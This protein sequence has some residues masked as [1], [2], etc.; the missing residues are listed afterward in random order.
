M[1][2]SI[3]KGRSARI[4]ITPRRDTS[5]AITA[6]TNRGT[7]TFKRVNTIVQPAEIP[8]SVYTHIPIHVHKTL[9]FR[10]CINSLR[11]YDYVSLTC[12]RVV[13]KADY[14]RWITRISDIRYYMSF[15]YTK[16]PRDRSSYYR[17]Y[18]RVVR[19]RRGF[20]VLTLVSK[21]SLKLATFSLGE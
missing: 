7:Y 5:Q 13:A 2:S 15:I 20:F 16:F 3:Y 6:P 11:L 19:E 4:V 14:L 17:S 8:P 21:V 12:V 1:G 9:S 10:L 18:I